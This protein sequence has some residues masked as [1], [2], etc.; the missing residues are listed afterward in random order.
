M[1]A[2]QV[3]REPG[4]RWVIS[5][6]SLEQVSRRPPLR[7]E[8]ANRHAI[9]RDDDGLTVLDRI[10]DVGETPCRLRGS[11]RNHE[12]ILSDLVCLYVYGQGGLL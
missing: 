6:S 7:D 2:L 10:E 1:R 5:Q 11:H 4:V 9:T 12:C 8:P 3:V